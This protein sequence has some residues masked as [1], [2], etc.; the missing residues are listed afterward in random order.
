MKYIYK[1]YLLILFLFSHSAFAEILNAK[2]IGVYDGDTITVLDATNSQHKIRLSGI[3]APEKR[4]AFGNASKKSL[5]NLVFNKQV[6]IEWFKLDRYGR[7]V[8]KVIINGKD[9]NLE[10]INIG[11][12]WYFKKYKKELV[13]E[14]RLNYLHAQEYAERNRLG[15]WVDNDTVAPWTFRKGKK[16]DDH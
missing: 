10:Q 11:M 1:Y 8:G 15:L 7:K 5:S 16:T 13:L 3:D 6:D 4:Q 14:D 9:I 2:V 12:A